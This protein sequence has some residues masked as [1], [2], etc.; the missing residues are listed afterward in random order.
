ME[1]RET[2]KPCHL[3]VHQDGRASLLLLINFGDRHDM[4]DAMFR[5]EAR[6]NNG[7]GWSQV[8][9]TLI[10]PDIRSSLVFD[11]EADMVSIVG[12]DTEVLIR[13][14]HQIR[15][16]LDNNEALRKAIRDSELD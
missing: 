8:I 14:A 16:V 9:Q 10:S 7:Y 3:V 1:D 12:R 13:I 5:Q 2:I 15:R 11:A 6:E 4:I